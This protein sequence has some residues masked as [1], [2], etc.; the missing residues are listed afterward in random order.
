MTSTIDSLL[1]AINY[2]ASHGVE[3]IVRVYFPA[4]SWQR[5]MMYGFLRWLLVTCGA[6]TL[7][8]S[9]SLNSHPDKWFDET[10]DMRKMEKFLMLGR[11]NLGMMKEEKKRTQPTYGVAYNS[12][13]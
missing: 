13:A 8:P 1:N 3:K 2:I 5:N 12:C 10:K 9:Q 6:Q 7:E 4:T 11:P